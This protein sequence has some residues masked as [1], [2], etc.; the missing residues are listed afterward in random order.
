MTLNQKFLFPFILF[1]TTFVLFQFAFPQEKKVYSND[2]KI[3]GLTVGVDGVWKNGFQTPVTVSLSQK[4]NACSA[5]EM[6]SID[7]DGTPTIIRQTIADLPKIESYSSIDSTIESYQLY[8]PIGR[9]KANLT[10]RLLQSPLNDIQNETFFPVPQQILD[11]KTFS[12]TP[13]KSQINQESNSEFSNESVRYYPPVSPQKPVYLVVGN[14]NIGL[15]EVFGELRMKEER[16][17]LI[18]RMKRFAEFP[19]SWI[20]FEAVDT[21]IL[22]TTDPN[23]FDGI[24]KND[25]RIL[26]L[27]RWVQWGGRLV[28]LAGKDSIPL[29]TNEGPLACF[30]PGIPDSKPREIRIANDLVQFVPKAKNLVMNGSLDFP[31]LNTPVLRNLTK[32]SILDIA[33]M[34]TPILVRTPIGFGTIIFLA[35]DL[36]EAPLS[37]WNGRSGLIIR[38]LGF[39][40]ENQSKQT[41]DRSLVRLGYSDLSGQLRSVLDRFDNVRNIPFSLILLLIFLYI[42]VIGPGDWF[43]V[44]KLLKRPNLTW[45]TFPC[46]IILFCAIVIGIGKTMQPKDVR[47]NQVDLIDI[48]FDSGTVRGTVWNNIYSPSDKKYSLLLKNYPIFYDKENQTTF[49]SETKNEIYLSWFGLQG[50]GLG[51]M[52]PK[53][54]SPKI[55]NNPYLMDYS[56]ATLDMIPIPVRSSK[57]LFGRYF[58]EYEKTFQSTLRSKDSIPVGTIVNPFDVPIENAVLFYD[59]WAVNL[60]TLQPGESTINS[61]TQ[62]LEYNRVLNGALTP[63]DDSAKT[64]TQQ[65]LARYNTQSLN[66]PYILKTMSFY[67]L[68]GGFDSVGLDNSLQHY[69]DGSELIRSGRAILLGTIRDAS[70]SIQMNEPA[71]LQ[72]SS[73]IAP[74]SLGCRLFNNGKFPSSGVIQKNQTNLLGTSEEIQKNCLTRQTIVVRFIL[75]VEK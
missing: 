47:V 45:L 32:E 46:Y 15:N 70:P 74:Y 75:P 20:G 2:V 42:L 11:E 36:S 44:H 17:P 34:E 66:I 22:T 57:S 16:R 41:S 63:F 28:I 49:D 19:Q 48:D 4:N 5:I 25:P 10:I 33:E 52:S 60:E 14:E 30:M 53:T 9:E 8:M 1:G 72:D 38:M 27:Q 7:S 37:N 6:E 24:T 35:L 62:R 68:S 50:S 40:N 21:I 29:I 65:G 12:P 51:G 73:S 69:L 54:I 26:A 31:Y 58:S 23:F 55:W 13:I 64:L 61:K 59:R 43:I 67:Q 3:Q 39:D 56:S 18:H 71:P